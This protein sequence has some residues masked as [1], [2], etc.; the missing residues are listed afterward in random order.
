MSG[1]K[2]GGRTLWVRIVCIVL[3]FLMVSSMLLAVLDV[4]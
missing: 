3:A 2:S 1:K 4:F